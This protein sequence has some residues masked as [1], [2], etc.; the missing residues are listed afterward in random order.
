MKKYLAV[1]TGI[2]AKREEWE[3]LDPAERKTRE[4]AGM[5]AWKKWAESEPPRDQGP[6]I[7]ARQD[8]A[9]HRFG[10]RRYAQ[11]PRGLYGRRSG[12]P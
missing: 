3:R 7:A 2:P 1:Y 10:R 9:G 11:Q 4:K 12:I 6:G 8:Q 5:D